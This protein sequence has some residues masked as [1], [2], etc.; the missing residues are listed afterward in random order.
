MNKIIDKLYL[1]N[2]SAANNMHALKSAGIT[3]IL[4]VAS[5]VEP[6]FEGKFKYRVIKVSDTSSSSLI[7]HFPAAIQFIKE[8]I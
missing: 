8:G 6:A 4:C 5:G 2:I 1:G 7:R 3:H